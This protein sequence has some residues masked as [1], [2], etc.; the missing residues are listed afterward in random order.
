MGNGKGSS[1]PRINTPNH[2]MWL[3]PWRT[4]REE[5]MLSEL[6]ETKRQ[7]LQGHWGK[8][9]L[10]QELVLSLSSVVIP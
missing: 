9:D 3:P 8:S 10:R 1:P 7:P 6:L 2:E 5:E 4:S